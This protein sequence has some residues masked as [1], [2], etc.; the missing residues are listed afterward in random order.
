[1]SKSS[2]NVLVILSSHGELGGKPNGT[3]MPELTHALHALEAAGLSWTLATPAGGEAPGYGHEADALTKQMLSEGP[4]AEAIHQTQRLSE[5]HAAGFDAVFY[6]GGYGLLFDL[7]EDA[8]SHRLATEVYER[9]GAVAAVCHGP[10]ALSRVTLSDGAR[11]ID[12][13]EVTGF[14]REEEVA[15]STLELIPFLL[16]H[17][18][19]EAG[20][21]Y[22]KRK[23]WQTLVVRD[24]R[25]ITG[26]NPGSAAG[27]G[28][29]LAEVLGA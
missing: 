9:G 11:L 6:P 7:V 1:M 19:I 22:R 20:A 13:R 29:A 24:G 16:E 10:A 8:D 15:M 2:K 12:G 17:A 3:Y 18:M 21:T 27:V 4:L 26:Q 5:V 28:E 23:A 14:T 25:L